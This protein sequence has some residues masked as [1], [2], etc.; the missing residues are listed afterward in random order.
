MKRITVAYPFE[1]V[2]GKLAGDQVL[3]YAENNNPAFD[4]PTGRQYARNYK[5]CM[6]A[7]KRSATGKT[8]FQIKTKTATKVN[9]GSKLRMALLGG[10]GACRAAILSN[11]T[12]RAQVEAIYAA[13]KAEGRTSAK[14]VEKYVYDVVYEGLRAKSVMFTFLSAGGGTLNVHNPWVYTNQQAGTGITIKTDILVKFWDQLALN[15]VSY[16]VDGL[17]GIAHS[18][19]IFDSDYIS[20]NLNVLGLTIANVDVSGTGK[21]CVCLGYGG[22]DIPDTLQVLTYNGAP[23]ERE[24]AIANVEYDVVAMPHYD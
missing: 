13:A 22:G 1:D 23:V 20:S 7:C 12:L 24:T 21:M 2:R 3:E 6:I 16:K 8:Y 17:K 11:G 19:D 14:T 15:P 18:G 5:A 9:A 4:A 10:T